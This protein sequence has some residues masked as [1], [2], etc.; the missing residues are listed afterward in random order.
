MLPN[1]QGIFDLFYS[2]A[3]PSGPMNSVLNKT[4]KGIFFRKTGLL[5]DDSYSTQIADP[6]QW[7]RMEAE[8]IYSLLLSCSDSKQLI[9]NAYGD[10]YEFS[11]AYFPVIGERA[12]NTCM[13]VVRFYKTLDYLLC[14]TKNGIFDKGGQDSLE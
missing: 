9:F 13:V 12:Q 1:K 2:V 6:R 14:I 3:I 7:P 5:L 10:H 4:A 11:F 8:K